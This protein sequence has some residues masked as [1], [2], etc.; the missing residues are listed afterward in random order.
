MTNEIKCPICKT[1][2]EDVYLFPDLIAKFYKWNNV[3]NNWYC[4]RHSIDDIR[5]FEEF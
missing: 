1:I 2:I 4:S 3:N 5:N